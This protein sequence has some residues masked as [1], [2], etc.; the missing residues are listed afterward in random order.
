MLPPKI[1]CPNKVFPDFSVSVKLAYKEE[2]GRHV[3]A[4][5]NVRAGEVVAVEDPAIS[6][7]NFEERGS[8]SFGSPCTHCFMRN[9]DCLPSPFSNTVN[10][11][12]RNI[13]K[14]TN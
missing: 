14:I 10:K 5:R 11:L 3:I 8:A 13:E 1:S 2:V 9:L 6:F 7:L 12:N 4:T